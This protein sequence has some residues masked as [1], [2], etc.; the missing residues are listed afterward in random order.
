MRFQTGPFGGPNVDL[1]VTFQT[2]GG[3]VFYVNSAGGGADDIDHPFP[4]IDN[5]LCFDTLQGAID[6]T[7]ADRGDVI[8]VKR[9]YT[10]ITTGVN[11]NKQGI[12]VIGQ[13]FGM[14]P[15]YRGEYFA[16]DA[17][18]VTDGPA[19]TISKPCY[20]EG[21]GFHTAWTGGIS[22][23]GLVEFASGDSGWIHLKNCRFMNWEVA[24]VYGINFEAG[25]NCIIED[26]SFEGAASQAFVSAGI[27]FGGSA[28]QNP[29]RNI[30]R[31]CVFSNCTY[32]IEH[33]D[34]TVQ[35][36]I[37]GPGN[38]TVKGLSN[39]TKFLNS[40]SAAGAGI[41]CGNFFHTAVGTG[42]FDQT[43]ANMET[44]GLQCVGNE[45]AT[46]GPGPT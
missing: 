19:M 35:E 3:K 41:I 1:D 4:P 22:S 13:R 18:A 34:G 24:T 9:G 33:K 15:L 40:K 14:P 25:A 38:I 39:D 2:I 10:T 42:T 37:Y 28:T 36:F 16:Q 12:S 46:E 5:V 8:F 44:D 7:V 32:A 29:I 45:Y 30:V 6:A 31:N 20:I 27:A 11:F 26:C 21:L 17:A 23:I 43:V